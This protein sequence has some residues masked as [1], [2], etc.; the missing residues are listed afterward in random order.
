MKKRIIRRLETKDGPE[1][2]P[3]LISR[4]KGE[5]EE[6]KYGKS[7]SGGTLRGETEGF[8]SWAE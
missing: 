3:A 4:E 1:D 7:S 5:L 8:T 6:D 2:K